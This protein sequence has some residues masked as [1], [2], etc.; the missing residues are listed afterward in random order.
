MPDVGARLAELKIADFEP[1]TLPDRESCR[2]LRLAQEKSGVTMP[3]RDLRLAP[4]GSRAGDQSIEE[5]IYPRFPG[6]FPDL[7]FPPAFR[8]SDS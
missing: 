5:V 7:N 4:F 6:G 2:V 3:F 1:A 8:F